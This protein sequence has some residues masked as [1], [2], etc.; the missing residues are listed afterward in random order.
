MFIYTMAVICLWKYDGGDCMAKRGC[1]EILKKTLVEF[2]W[3]P[4]GLGHGV[5]C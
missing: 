1:H 4:W 2:P 5:C 3:E